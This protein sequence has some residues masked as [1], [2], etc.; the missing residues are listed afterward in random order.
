MQ[1]PEPQSLPYNV[2]LHEIEKGLLKVPQFQ[3]EFVWSREK[4]AALIDSILRGYPIGT[5]ILWKT[6]ESLRAI[7]N[8]GNAKLPTT[9]E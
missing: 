3:R 5:F 1:Q 8:I 4:S 6:K 2:L 9:P 7:R